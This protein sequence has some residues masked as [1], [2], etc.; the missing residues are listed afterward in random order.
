MSFNSF[1]YLNEQNVE[2]IKDM[3]NIDMNDELYLGFHSV[4]YV[5]KDIKNIEIEIE[6]SKYLDVDFYEYENS[7]GSYSYTS[8]KVSMDLIKKIIKDI[9]DKKIISYDDS[10][11]VIVYANKENI[12][13]LKK[14][15]IIRDSEIDNYEKIIEN[16]SVQYNELSRKFDSLK[17]RLYEE[18]YYVSFESNGNIIIF[19]EREE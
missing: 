9:N 11:K 4:T 2:T 3:Y 15:K 16:Q 1:E 18:G 8:F 7:V 5:E 12:E 19:E 17:E 10:Y 14:N 13:I 6:H